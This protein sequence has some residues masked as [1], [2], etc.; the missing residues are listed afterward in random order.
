MGMIYADFAILWEY[1]IGINIFM[2][3]FVS[4]KKIF[5]SVCNFNKFFDSSRYVIN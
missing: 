1:L 2:R 4:G 5:V 3:F